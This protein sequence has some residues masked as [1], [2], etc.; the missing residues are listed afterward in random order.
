MGERAGQLGWGKSVCV[1]RQ[2]RGQHR[3]WTGG[4][5]PHRSAA[6]YGQSPAGQSPAA[7]VARSA[8]RSSRAGRGRARLRS[9][10]QR[11]VHHDGQLI[12]KYAVR[13]A[14]DEVAAFGGQGFGAGPCR[15]SVKAMVSSGTRRRMAG[16]GPCTFLP[17]ARRSG[18]GRCPDRPR[19]RRT[20]VARRPHARPHAN[21]SRD[22]PALLLEPVKIVLIDG[23]ARTLIIGAVRPA[24]GA[25]GIPGQPQPGQV[26]LD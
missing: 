4:G 21:R 8:A 17:P 3:A 13:A 1:A 26:V 2:G 14:D 23:R 15:P 18:R 22:R 6:G 12:G 20:G 24:L 11:I 7:G 10:P 19:G 25:A 5:R 16:R 9:R